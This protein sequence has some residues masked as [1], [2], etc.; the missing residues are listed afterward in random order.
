MSFKIDACPHWK[1]PELVFLLWNK[2]LFTRQVLKW[3]LLLALPKYLFYSCFEQTKEK[4]LREHAYSM[5]EGYVRPSILFAGNVQANNHAL[6]LHIDFEQTTRH[7][8]L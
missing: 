5:A 8:G 6:S 4:E 7:P 2:F 1:D 3:Q